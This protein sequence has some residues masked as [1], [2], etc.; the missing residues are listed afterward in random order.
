MKIVLAARKG[1]PVQRRR[2]SRLAA[3]QGDV[4]GWVLILLM[5]SALVLAIWVI[6]REQLTD[7]VRTALDTVCGTLG[8]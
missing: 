3:E 6:A 8:C 4:P 2:R 1:D 7:I 5:T